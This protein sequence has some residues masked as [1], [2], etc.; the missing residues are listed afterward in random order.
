MLKKLFYLS[1]LFLL[2]TGIGWLMNRPY[3]DITQIEIVGANGT[4]QYVDKQNVF[5]TVL[6]YVTG[7]FFQ[8]NI[9]DTQK[10]AQSIEW[11]K[12]AKVDRIPPNRIKITIEEYTP[13][14]RWIRDGYEAGLISTN[15]EVFQ[16]KY[17]GNLPEF[18]G[19]AVAQQHMLEQYTML[20]SQLST[21]RLKI[22]RLQYSPS[23]AWSM[24]L[25]NGIEIR[26][27]R[28]NIHTRILRF[29][30]NYH[31][32]ILPHVAHLDYID[33]RYNNAFA[34]KRRDD[35]PNLETIAQ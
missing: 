5:K 35:A 14:A 24:I 4:L 30:E 25:D 18:D 11:V 23:A 10:V 29:V 33:M 17:V 20:N 13:M 28:D 31:T 26:L 7:N 1:M 34:V 15:G 21:L 27:G 32:Q 12:Y 8:I 6:P 3:F 9:Q 16:A 2:I 22:L 19:T